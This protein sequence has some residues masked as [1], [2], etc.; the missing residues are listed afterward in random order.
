MSAM[1][2]VRDVVRQRALALNPDVAAFR[3]P[4]DL[5]KP[6]GVVRLRGDLVEWLEHGVEKTGRVIPVR[7]GE[8]HAG[9]RVLLNDAN[10][11]TDE[12]WLCEVQTSADHQDS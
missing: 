3:V 10:G 11:P 6:T 4:Y 5:F 8:T 7:L 1:I 12:W 2:H 9:E